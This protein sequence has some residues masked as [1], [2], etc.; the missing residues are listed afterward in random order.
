M[1]C[2]HGYF[3][4][5][6]AKGKEWRVKIES[7]K[8]TQLE[9]Y[10]CF[11]NQKFIELRTDMPLIKSQGSRRKAKWHL[12]TGIMKDERFI[13]NLKDAITRRLKEYESGGWEARMEYMQ[14]RKR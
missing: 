12:I 10:R 9:I 8:P 7:E 5:Y 6:D 3:S 11:I 13:D 4:V 1:L 2:F 14:S